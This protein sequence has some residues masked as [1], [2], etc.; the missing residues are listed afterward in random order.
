[1]ISTAFDK[2][3][4]T[5]ADVNNNSVV[6]WTGNLTNRAINIYLR[7]SIGNETYLRAYFKDAD[8]NILSF[9]N[10]DGVKMSYIESYNNGS[11]SSYDTY[12]NIIVPAGATK[13]TFYSN[14][15]NGAY[16]RDIHVIEEDLICPEPVKNI[17]S[18][19]DEISISLNWE[20]SNEDYQK[21]L[22]FRDNLIIG[23]TTGLTFTDKPLFSNKEYKY[24]LQII[25]KNGNA[26]SRVE[27]ITKTAETS[28]VFSGLEATAFDKNV[29]TWA[30][31]NNS[32]V[33]T[34]TGDLSNKTLN[35]YLRKSTG[36]QTYLRA[37]FRDASDNVLTFY[38][39]SGTAM[40]YLQSY[41]NGSQSSYDTYFKVIV[42]AGA[43]KI[44]FYSDFVYGTYVRDIHVAE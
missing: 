6:T 20:Q 22:I 18:V 15:E 1:M 5:W 16:V 32:S 31:V 44:T 19:S 11:Q 40:T 2:N 42:P 24:E 33:I 39:T 43:T 37:Y 29:S 8:N 23:S 28:I 13:I 41:N 36:N 14:F 35:V 12:F 3:I 9:Y 4:S 26:S 10:T 30:G 17:T 38:N 21:T 25:D 7:K 27:Y 34:W